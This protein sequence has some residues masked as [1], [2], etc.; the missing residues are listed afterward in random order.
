[1]PINQEHDLRVER[2]LTVA[3]G[4]TLAQRLNQNVLGKLPVLV[5]FIDPVTPLQNPRHSVRVT[6]SGA[7]QPNPTA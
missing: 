7:R 3:Q 4:F 2:D 5:V 6:K 1:V